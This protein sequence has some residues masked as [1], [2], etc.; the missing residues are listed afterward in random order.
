MTRKL[1]RKLAG[2]IMILLSAT[3]V[4]AEILPEKTTEVTVSN[5]D[6]NRIVCP[7]NIQDV[8]YSQEKGLQVKTEGRNLYVKLP[9]IVKAVNGEVKEKKLFKNKAELFISCGG[10]V[11]SLILKP[12]KI[13]ART[14]YLTAP[15]EDMKKA[16]SFF[17]K[18]SFEDAIVELIKR[19]AEERIPRGFKVE[20]V[21]QTI[22]YKD[23]EVTFR[24]KVIG[25]GVIVKEFII[26]S[27]TPR[28]IKN[29][30]LLDLKWVEN[31]KTRAIATEDNYFKGFTRA[32][33]VET[34]NKR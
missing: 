26:Y 4:F 33:S 14:I 7:Y 18:M 34:I 27:K 13:P 3:N 6:V 24:K 19:V 10:H 30:D 17:E 31:S 5:I 8:V 9:I 32:Y 23:M 28:I 2:L 29:T 15:D 25:G 20:F 22:Q 21:N 12:K 11:Y 16:S 1:A